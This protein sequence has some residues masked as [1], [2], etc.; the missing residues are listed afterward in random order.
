MACHYRIDDS[1]GR[2]GDD[3]Y[4]GKTKKA[5]QRRKKALKV[6]GRIYRHCAR[7]G[8]KAPRTMPPALQWAYIGIFGAGIWLALR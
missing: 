3:Y 7:K 2:T 5:A 4:G 6:T 1:K 8:A